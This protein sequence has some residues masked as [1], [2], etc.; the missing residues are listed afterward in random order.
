[1]VSRWQTH[2]LIKT[3]VLSQLNERK[4]RKRKKN[5]E[6]EEELHKKTKDDIFE[7]CTVETGSWM[8]QTYRTPKQK[9]KAEV[10]EI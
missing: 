10:Q 2:H 4:R 1:M 6:N 9:R 5:E 8:F 3:F 7:K